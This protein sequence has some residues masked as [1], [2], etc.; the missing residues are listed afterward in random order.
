MQRLFAIFIS[1]TISILSFTNI[2]LFDNILHNA[3]RA[4]L[5][6]LANVHQNGQHGHEENNARHR[7]R[8]SA[9]KL[10]AIERSGNGL[11]RKIE[12]RDPGVTRA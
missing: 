8:R 9:D 5:S 7:G 1:P 3:N 10:A 2:L 6:Y 11:K 4:N 12:N